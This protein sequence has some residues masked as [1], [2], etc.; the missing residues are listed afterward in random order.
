LRSSTSPDHFLDL[1]DFGGRELPRDRWKAITL[2]IE[3]KQQPDRTG[4]LPWAIMENFDRLSCAFYDHRQDPKNAAIQAK[5]LVHAR[6]RAHCAGDAAMPLH[7]T[8]DYDG[9]KKDGKFVQRGIH[10]KIDALPERHKLS[11]EEISR[12]LKAKK[13]D[14]AWDH[15]VKTIQES[16]T[17]IEKCYEL[18]AAGA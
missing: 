4:M 10:A 3:I 14:N 13:L 2:L 5:C 18:D 6:V 15:V 9:R 1:E 16:H 17:H 8:R 11:A 12:E 7:T